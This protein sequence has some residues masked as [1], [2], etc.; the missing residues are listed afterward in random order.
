MAQRAAVQAWFDSEQREFVG[1]AQSLTD[2]QWATQSLCAEWSVR[3]LIVHVAWHI[4][5]AKIAPKEALRLVRL[6]GMDGLYERI[7]EENR[8]RS[9][10]ELVAWLR[11]KGRRN[12]A[13][14]VELI[15]HQQDVRVPLGIPRPIPPD[16]LTWLLAF[17]MTPAGSRETGGGPRK[18]AEGLRLV[19]SDLDW[20]NGDGPEVRGPGQAL[21]LTICG[22]PGFLDDLSG[23]G[24]GVLATRGAAPA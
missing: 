16:Q 14:L 7:L 11:S 15:M 24:V 21:L 18:R 1:L 8:D 20:S 22:R 2:E 19:A 6:G 23:A 3:E 12:P 10:A 4:H 5:L 9:A 17:A 13:N